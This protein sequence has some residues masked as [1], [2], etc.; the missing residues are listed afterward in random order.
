MV[1]SLHA[2][3]AVHGQVV[4]WGMAKP[5]TVATHL[6]TLDSLEGVLVCYRQ[7][8][9]PQLLSAQEFLRRYEAWRTRRGG[10]VFV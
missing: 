4:R 2:W 5:E 10:T 9:K 6:G 1:G 8:G 3:I 7:Y